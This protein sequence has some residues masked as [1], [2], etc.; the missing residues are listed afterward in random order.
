MGLRRNSLVLH[1]AIQGERMVR[2]EK[3]TID[4]FYDTEIVLHIH[5]NGS[6]PFFKP[7]AQI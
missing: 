1:R 7:E 4:A 3:G 6:S 2:N 5:R